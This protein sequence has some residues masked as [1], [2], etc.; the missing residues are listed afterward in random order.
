MGYGVEFQQPAMIA[1]DLAMT[2]SHQDGSPPIFRA[3]A[4]RAAVAGPSSRTLLSL[5]DEASRDAVL[6]KGVWGSA[7]HAATVQLAAQWT[8]GEAQV[9]AKLAELCNVAAYL[10]GATQ[11]ADHP[12]R[13]DFHLLHC[14]NATP[15]LAAMVRCSAFAEPARRDLLERNGRHLLRAYIAQRCPTPHLDR[16]QQAA[17]GADVVQQQWDG[18]ARRVMAVEDDSHLIKAVRALSG[19]EGFPLRKDDWLKIGNLVADLAEDYPNG[20]HFFFGAI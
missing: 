7:G 20:E 14:L 5:L 13:F 18:I 1:E 10:F 19:H 12:R 9:E 11:D 16:V 6:C 3:A 17:P 2:A 8:V 4:E 15:M